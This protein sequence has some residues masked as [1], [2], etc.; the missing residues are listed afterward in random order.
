[1]LKMNEFFKQKSLYTIQSGKKIIEAVMY[2]AEHNVGLIPVLDNEKLIGV[3][4][5]RDLMRRVIAK[6]LDLADTIVDDIMTKEL[7]LA[8]SDESY[9]A[10]LMKMKEAKIRHILI[11]EDEKLLGVLSIRDLLEID[12]SAKKETIEVLN[13]YIY[14]R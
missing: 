6:G 4:S 5:E 1:M 2:M 3:F 13:N 11:I 9:E 12:I 14:S 8:K 10:C 7:I